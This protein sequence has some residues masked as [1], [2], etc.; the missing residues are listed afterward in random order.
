MPQK[1][2]V[3]NTIESLH[4]HQHE[5]LSHTNEPNRKFVTEKHPTYGPIVSHCPG[6]PRKGSPVGALIGWPEAPELQ[7][8]SQTSAKPKMAPNESVESLGW[9]RT[10][11]TLRLEAQAAKDPVEMAQS[12]RYEVPPD[13]KP[14]FGTKIN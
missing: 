7:W 6:G 12:L 1:K 5:V 3:R 2:K 13:G 4:Q 11:L 9:K 10:I 8:L 14:S